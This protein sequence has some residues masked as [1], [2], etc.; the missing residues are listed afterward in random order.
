MITD[1]TILARLTELKEDVRRVN[2][3]EDLPLDRMQIILLL[4]DLINELVPD[5]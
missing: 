3:Y 2:T 5:E 4:E 1:K